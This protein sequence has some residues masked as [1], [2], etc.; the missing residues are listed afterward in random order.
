MNKII[1]KNLMAQ[2]NFEARG[3]PPN[4]RPL[5]AIS[6]CYPGLEFDFRNIWKHFFVG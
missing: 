5:S 6:N 1:P 4:T 3:N 2:M